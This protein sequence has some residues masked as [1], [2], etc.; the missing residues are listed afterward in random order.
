MSPD[1]ADA[2]GELRLPAGAC[3]PAALETGLHDDL[4][5]LVGGRRVLRAIVP[6]S[7]LVVPL[8]DYLS[9]VGFRRS[10]RRTPQLPQRRGAAPRVADLLP[11]L[12][13]L[14]DPPAGLALALFGG[15]LLIRRRLEP[16][17]YAAGAAPLVVHLLL[18]DDAG[19]RR[20]QVPAA[21][22]AAVA[23]YLGVPCVGVEAPPSST[24]SGRC[25]TFL[26]LALSV[27]RGA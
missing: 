27:H 22:A 25:S 8:Y 14:R 19:S 21:G 7:G 24:A 5:K 6:E 2:L 17:A 1:T 13:R 23:G 3:H 11:L 18:M 15:L 26:I 10:A 4:G 16:K 12:H 9:G 20:S